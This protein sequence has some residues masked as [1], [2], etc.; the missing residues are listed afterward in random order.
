MVASMKQ[1]SDDPSLPAAATPTGRARVTPARRRRQALIWLVGLVVTGVMLGLGLWQMQTFRTQGQDA[2]RARMT[3]AAVPLDSVLQ[4]GEIP[5]DGYGRPVTTTGR[6]LPEQQVLV[7]EPNAPGRF[8]V[9]TALR[10][11]DGTVLPVV[12][13]VVEGTDAPPPPAGEVTQTGLLLPTEAEPESPAPAGQLGTVR[14]Q[15]LAQLWPD[16][17]M[18]GFLSLDDA[19]AAAQGMTAAQVDVPSAAGQAR[20]NGYALQW[21]IFAA[22]AVAATIKLSRDAGRGTSL[23]SGDEVDDAGD[24]PVEKSGDDVDER[25]GDGAREA[26][27]EGADDAS[28]PALT[29]GNTP[30]AGASGNPREL[31]TTDR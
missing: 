23:I 28:I 30:D 31:G 8:R 26:T 13:G 19:G 25:P 7:P 21:W 29:R 2:M 12:R 22:A 6:Y 18:P 24:N 15:R 1:P 11:A 9:V 3:Q 4:V 10:L 27:A 14:L 17:L 16:Q 20:N 5:K